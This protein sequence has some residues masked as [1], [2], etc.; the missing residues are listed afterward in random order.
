MC[1]PIFWLSLYLDF[2]FPF[3]AF[4][5]QTQAHFCGTRHT[6][7]TIPF[8]MWIFLWFFLA[9]SLEG[10]FAIKQILTYWFTEPIF[11]FFVVEFITFLAQSNCL[12]LALT[13]MHTCSRM[14][15]NLMPKCQCHVLFPFCFKSK[16]RDSNSFKRQQI[17]TCVPI[18]FSPFLLSPWGKMR[19]VMMANG[20]QQRSDKA[21][22]TN[23]MSN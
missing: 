22:Q 20:T 15:S 1:A 18:P 9:Q 11:F 13:L 2:H 7:P 16:I 19:H 5:T 14:N 23:K 3:T 17:K 10:T 21:K 6:D 4:F 8:W 12:F